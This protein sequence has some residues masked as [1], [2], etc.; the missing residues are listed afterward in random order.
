MFQ[1]GLVKKSLNLLP[2]FT[3]GQSQSC[4][5]PD[6]RQSELRADVW[7]ERRDSTEPSL[8][9]QHQL[10][11]GQSCRGLHPGYQS[12]AKVDWVQAKV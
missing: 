4:L 6:D 2:L 11:P 8:C 5:R 3:S 7:P 12:V 1:S 10:T 9:N